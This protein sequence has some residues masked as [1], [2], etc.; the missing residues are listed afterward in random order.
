MNCQ[1]CSGRGWSIRA[2]DNYITMCDFCR[3]K[4][5][6]NWLEIIFGVREDYAWWEDTTRE[7]NKIN[8]S[9]LEKNKNELSEM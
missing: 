7:L 6:L 4:R 1:K 3:G 8:G 5:K 2:D 9:D